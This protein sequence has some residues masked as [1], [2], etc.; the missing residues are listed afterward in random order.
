M[1]H[2]ELPALF[3]GLTGRLDQVV[4]FDALV[5]VLHDAATNTMC[6]RLLE[7]TEPDPIRGE[8]ALPVEDDPAGMVW[9]TQQ[10]L[11]TS[12]V[13]ELKRWPR[14]LELVEPTGVQSNCWLPLTTV[15]QRLGALVFASKQPSA[16]DGADLGFMQLVANQVAVAI[17]N[18]LAFQEIEALKDQ[19]SQEKA[20]LEEEVR[21]DQNFGDVVGASDALPGSSRKLRLSPRPIPPFS[22][23]AKRALA[24]SLLLVRCTT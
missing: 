16:Y 13:Y 2:R 8:F 17:D 6:L 21:T 20:Y 14:L 22:F 18:A 7:T 4:Q 3:R 11:I 23:V 10:P 5:L 1:S 12:T 9:K 19:L 15:R 24:R